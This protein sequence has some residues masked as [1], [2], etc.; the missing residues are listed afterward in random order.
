MHGSVRGCFELRPVL[1]PE[2]DAYDCAEFVAFAFDL[3][4]LWLEYKA[5]SRRGEQGGGADAEN[6]G[7]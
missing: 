4:E 2:R 6:Y 1:A 5:I 7:A 3:A